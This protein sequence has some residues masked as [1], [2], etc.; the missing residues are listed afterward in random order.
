[1]PL[2]RTPS[3]PLAGPEHREV[4]VAPEMLGKSKQVPKLSPDQ[5]IHIFKLGQ[6][7]TA[8]TAG[9]IAVEYGVTVQDIRDIWSLNVTL[10][11]QRNP[12]YPSP[13]E[14]QPG[15]MLCR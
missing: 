9:L 15:H 3:L 2:Q 5:T 4:S 1:M 8:N 14:S 11:G 6:S 7:M 10:V 12:V 13:L